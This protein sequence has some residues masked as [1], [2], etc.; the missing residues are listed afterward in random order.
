MGIGVGQSQLFYDTLEAAMV[1]TLQQKIVYP[2]LTTHVAAPKGNSFLWTS[3]KDRV[4]IEQVTTGTEGKNVELEFNRNILELTERGAVPRVMDNDINDARWDIIQITLDEVGKAFARAMNTDYVTAMN[5][6]VG[7]IAGT[8]HTVA[9]GATWAS[10]SADILN[11]LKTAM[12]TAY[13]DDAEVDALVLNPRD[14]TSM[15]TQPDF[16]RATPQ[17]DKALIEGAVDKVFGLNIFP[18]NAVTRGTV[19]GTNS[20]E[21]VNFYEREPFSTE[22]RKPSRQRA[23]DIICWAR[24]GFA[25]IRPQMLFKITGVA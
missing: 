25:V 9:A 22:F 13:A 21:A 6:A 17:G 14:Y 20:K 5:T 4:S 1:S 19:Y 8:T 11:D 18:T 16:L 10:S 3:V 23:T 7:A 12:D 2:S 24:Y 15:L